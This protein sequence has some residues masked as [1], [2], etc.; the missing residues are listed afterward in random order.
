MSLEDVLRALADE[1]A[2]CAVFADFDGTLA[3]VIEDRD[4][5]VPV[6]GVIDRVAELS[7]RIGRFAVVSGRPVSFLEQFFPEHIELSGLYGIEHWTDGRML[8]DRAALEWLPVVRTTARVATEEFGA[9]VVENKTYSMT[10]HYRHDGDPAFGQR[11]TAWAEHRAHMTGLE[12]RVAKMSIELH[13]PVGRT[14]ADA[15]ADMLTRIRS[16]AFFGDDVGDIPAFDLLAGWS[17]AG[18]LDAEARVLVRSAETSPA[19]EAGSTDVCDSPAAV[20]DVFDR[21]IEAAR[22]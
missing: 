11:V 6:E 3:H 14:K 16:A 2:R 22:A 1:P 4:A 17:A 7:A 20:V 13:P 5:V 12:A 21:M 9:A 15:V 8:V 19:L 18:R 10:L